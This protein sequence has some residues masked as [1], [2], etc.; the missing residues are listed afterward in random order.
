MGIDLKKMKA[1][2]DALQNKGGGKTSFWRPEEGTNYS[3][4]VV[5]TADGDPFKEYWFHYEVGKG[6]I[7]CPKKNHGEECAI[8]AF[9]SKLYKENTEESNKMAKKFL[10]RQRFFA[11]V[12]VRGEEKEGIRL[13]GFGK[14]VYQDL[15]NLVLNPDYGDITDP[16]TGTDLAIMASKVPG[17][18]FPTTK[19]TPAR[20]TSKLCQGSAEECKEL[21]ES[22]PNFDEA[23]ERKTSQ[24]VATILDEYL[25]SGSDSEAEGDS[26]E[27]AK[28]GKGSKSA[29]AIDAAFKELMG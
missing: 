29:S 2:L 13:W 10:A 14:I 22:V 23:F 16:E 27:T 11:P 17:A 25:A 18:S 4:R 12:V 5:S 26:K 9:A 28:Y 21:L 19:L 6:S 8:C 7:L 1:K 3:I 24:E 15:I 20:K